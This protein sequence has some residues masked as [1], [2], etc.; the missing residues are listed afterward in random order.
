V[1]PGS[2]ARPDRRWRALLE[3]VCARAVTE[4]G[5]DHSVI[6]ITTGVQDWVP[7]A[8]SSPAAALLDECA[9]TLGEGPC[10]DAITEH[11]P[12]LARDLHDRATASRWPMWS[13]A[14]EQAGVRAV[15]AMPLEAG[16][17]TAGVLS[18]Y[19]HQAWHPTDVQFAAGRRL[20]DAALLVLLDMAVAV[21]EFESGEDGRY[22]ELPVLLRADVHRAAGMIMAQAGITIDQALARLRAYAF[23]TGR[24]LPDVPDDV[25][26]RRLRFAPDGESTQ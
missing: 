12:V 26:V 5:V 18:F 6:G 24:P 8:A 21:G 9:F 23:T 15:L 19:A 14:A 20:V 3:R 22:G 11:A 4:V 16:A 1:H 2:P 7:G 13:A 25:L 17:I 10:V